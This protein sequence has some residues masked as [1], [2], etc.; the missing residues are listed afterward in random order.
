MLELEK[1]S[2]NG[3]KDKKTNIKNKYITESH[4]NQ[5]K[6]FNNNQKHS[7]MCFQDIDNQSEN[8][9]ENQINSPKTNDLNKQ[10]LISNLNSPRIENDE[11][12]KVNY[13]LF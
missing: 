7:N 4:I 12:D 13:N 3:E 2:E 1:K 6:L 9:F 10:I 5:K 8:I 11:K